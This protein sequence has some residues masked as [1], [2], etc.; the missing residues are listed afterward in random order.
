MRPPTHISERNV[1]SVPCTAGVHAGCRG[2]RLGAAIRKCEDVDVLAT[3]G[4]ETGGTPARAKLGRGALFYLCFGL[5]LWLHLLQARLHPP[6]HTFFTQDGEG[7]EQRRSD[8]PPTDSHAKRLADLSQADAQLLENAGK[9]LF[10]RGRRP[11]FH[12][13]QV[14]Q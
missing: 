1:K 14:R 13:L 10:Q 3:A 11:V 5:L 12:P 9:L 2:V 4:L 8:R 7:I 6:D